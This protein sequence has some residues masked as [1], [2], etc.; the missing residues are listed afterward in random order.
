MW[1]SLHDSNR[2]VIEDGWNIFRRELV[3]GI[4]NEE[5]GLSDSTVTDDNTPG[6]GS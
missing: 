1:Y 4:R 6:G 2:I 3:G 5:T